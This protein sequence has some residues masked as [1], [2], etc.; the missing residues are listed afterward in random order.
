MKDGNMTIGRPILMG[1]QHHMPLGHNNQL[2]GGQERAGTARGRQGKVS[3]DVF[4]F[5]KITTG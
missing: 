2:A 3:C 4:S 5:G 1:L